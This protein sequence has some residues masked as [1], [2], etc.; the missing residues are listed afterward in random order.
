MNQILAAIRKGWLA[1]GILGLAGF[2]MGCFSDTSNGKGSNQAVKPKQHCAQ[3]VGERYCFDYDL[4]YL[5]NKDG[6][7]LQ[8]PLGA[9]DAECNRSR[10]LYPFVMVLFSEGHIPDPEVLRRNNRDWNQDATIEI[11]GK[12]DF[13]FRNSQSEYEECDPS[14]GGPPRITC[15]RTSNWGGAYLDFGYDQ[16]CRAEVREFARK[17]EEFIEKARK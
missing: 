10:E 5:P 3:V 12:K 7:L 11:F 14:K 2:L 17:L 4:A 1:I 16:Q 15:Q 8:L 9:L 6:V 13:L